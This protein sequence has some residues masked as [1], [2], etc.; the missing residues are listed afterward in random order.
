MIDER[1]NEYAEGGGGGDRLTGE[2][3]ARWKVR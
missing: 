3:T 1:V 2:R